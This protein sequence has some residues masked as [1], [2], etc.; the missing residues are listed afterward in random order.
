MSDYS[1]S[2]DY[3]STVAPSVERYSQRHWSGDRQRLEARS[4]SQ[5]SGSSA[6]VTVRSASA[7][8]SAGPHHKAAST[9]IADLQSDPHLG[10]YIEPKAEW[11]PDGLSFE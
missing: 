6:S 9:S 5:F 11:T 3:Y 8:R 10:G 1:Y 2:S 4:N 7:Q